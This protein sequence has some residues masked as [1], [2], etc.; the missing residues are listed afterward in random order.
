MLEA[1]LACRGGF[2]KV[3]TEREKNCQGARGGQGPFRGKKPRAGRL[4]RHGKAF[5]RK[6][7]LRGLRLR[8][9]QVLQ[10]EPSGVL[11]A[12]GKSIAVGA[13]VRWLE[14]KRMVCQTDAVPK[15][16]TGEV[17]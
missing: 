10:T 13:W 12:A 15:L 16:P 8:S 9:A 2:T 14:K 17:D 1:G 6:R 11:E 4:K 7:A 5:A 3:H